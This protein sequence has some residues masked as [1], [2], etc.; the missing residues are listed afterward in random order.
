MQKVTNGYNFVYA[1]ES[2]M[3]GAIRGKMDELGVILEIDMISLD[4]VEVSTLKKGSVFTMPGLKAH[5]V[6]TWV[7]AD[8][9]EDKISKQI[10]MQHAESTAQC[11]GGLMTY[12][13]R[14]FLYKF[15]SVPTDKDD[16]DNFDRSLAKVMDAPEPISLSESLAR[17]D[18]VN[19]LSMI[20]GNDSDYK[21]KLLRYFGLMEIKD[22]LQLP[23]KKI[24]AAIQ[25]A[26]KNAEGKKVNA[27]PPVILASTSAL[28][29][30]V[31]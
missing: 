9:P 3:L 8:K 21:D 30:Q 24:L 6:F 18:Q 12:A 1:T 25:S 22:F 28:T 16:P 27:S 15:F 31:F 4:P 29:P 20:I 13:N 5:F 2:Q 19:N 17:Q 14:Y 26:K 10:W 23:E 7:D 11:V